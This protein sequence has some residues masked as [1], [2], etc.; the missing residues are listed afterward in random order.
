MARILAYWQGMHSGNLWKLEPDGK[1]LSV[2]IKEVLKRAGLGPEELDY[3]CAH[4]TGTLANDASETAA[5]KAGL[6]RSAATVSI[7]SHKG[8]IGHLLGAAGAMQAVLAVK[9]I[10]EGIVPPTVNLKEPDP[11]CD[12]DYTQ[13]VPRHRPVRHALCITGGFGGQCGLVV[14]G[15]P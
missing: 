13:G 15:E 3:I 8:A 9:S 11:L 7:S 12:L 1:S 10:Q 2:G 14:L 6:G 5:I 4:G